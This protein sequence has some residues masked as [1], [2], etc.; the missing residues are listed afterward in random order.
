V[1]RAILSWVR[2]RTLHA[3]F[4][5]TGSQ[6]ECDRALGLTTISDVSL[7]NSRPARARRRDALTHSAVRLTTGGSLRPRCTD[8][9]RPTFEV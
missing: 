8:G 3:P 4:H 1:E 9:R 5:S 2:Y 6:V 7:R